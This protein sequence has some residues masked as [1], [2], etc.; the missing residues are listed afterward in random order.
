[1]EQYRCKQI[2]VY[3]ASIATIRVMARVIPQPS[4]LTI[5]CDDGDEHDD[6]IVDV[7]E[8]L[9]PTAACLSSLVIQSL[10]VERVVA[11]R[12]SMPPSITSV[13]LSDVPF[14]MSAPSLRQNVMIWVRV[15][16]TIF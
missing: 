15:H 12:W 4:D 5:I 9:L 13:T 3:G 11:T 6:P 7:F 8:P 10:G 2:S 14:I 16:V 1:M